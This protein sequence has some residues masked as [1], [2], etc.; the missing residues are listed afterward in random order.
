MK[1]LLTASCFLLPFIAR[2][3]QGAATGKITDGAARKG[4]A[5]ATITIFRAKD[6][7]IVT[8]RLSTETG[9]FKVPGLP[10]NLPLRLMVTFSG[11]EPL[12]KD[13][14]LTDRE[15]SAN[16]G[17]LAL[18]H[19]SKQLDEVIVFSER[20]P[21][22]IKKDTIEFN[23]SA[24]KTLPSA[25][26]EDLLKKL[27]GVIVNE[28][29]DIT[30][31]G[32]KVNRLLVDGKRFF[33]DNPQ[34]AT[35]NLPS[36]L[37]DKVQVMD[38]REEIDFNNDGD[39]SKI[40]KVI[41]ITLKKSIRKAMFGRVF[42]GGGTDSRYETGAI[43]NSF[44][45]TLQLSLV[46]FANNVNRASFTTKDVMQLGG[47]SRSGWGNLNGNSNQGGQQGFTIDGFSLGG[48][49]AGLNSANGIGINLN[50]SPSNKV[51]FSF[52]YMYGT[53]RN[54][55]E[56]TQNVQ[57]FFEDTIVNTRTVT[58]A[59][60]TSRTHN[61]AS[62]G[63]WKPDSLTNMTMRLA[64]AHSGSG[65]DAPSFIYTNNN[66]AGE[67]NNGSNVLRID[68]RS[69]NYSEV[70]MFSHRSANVK[71]RNLAIT[72]ALLHSANPV[73]TITESLIN[74]QYPASSSLSLQQLRATNTPST[75][76]F[77][78]VNYSTP[79][80][81]R[82]TFRLN[83][84][85]TYQENAQDVSTYG[86][87]LVTD[88]YDSLNS[89]LSSH[90]GR[91]MTRLSSSG[92]FS[93]RIGQVNLNAGAAFLQQW[94]NNHFTGA[95]KDSK[96]YYSDI[97][98][99]LSVNWK[100]ISLGFNQDVNAPGINYLIPT[101][102]NSNPFL[103]VY[104]NPALKPAK[105][106][107]LNF[108]GNL[109]NPK[110][111]LNFYFSGQST[112]TDNATIQ[113]V[114]LGSN[115]IQLNQPINV[116]GL[117]T[118]SLDMGFSKQYRNPQQLNITATMGLTGNLNRAPLRFNNEDSRLTNITLSGNAGIALNWKDLI[119]FN[120]RWQISSNH[121]S[122]S[123]RNFNGRDILMQV[124]QGEFIVRIPKIVW[125]TNLYYRRLNEVS[126]GLPN[127]SIYWNAAVTFLM[128][129]QDKG[130]LRIAVYDILN[131]NTNL[132]R[133][134]STNAIIDNRSNVLQR[135][136]LLTYTYQIRSFGNQPAKVGGSR[137]I[138]NF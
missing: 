60:A 53:T 132:S 128:F 104:G 112:L 138:F 127:T 7:S 113:S 111:N 51:N 117:W 37:I 12:R 135:Y 58:T 38:D 48:T 99:N 23:A 67:V 57:R 77:L 30:V 3:Q 94:I 136:F 47:F 41:N 78:F 90:L 92:V 116:S 42:A 91:E 8:Y 71:G 32:Q 29:G 46:G 102:D 131:S 40:G 79:L 73:S 109:P 106:N 5:L 84:F 118:N 137:S 14:T 86:K 105:R 55:L 15:P 10:F 33:G 36:N 66:K 133:Y 44:R 97:L 107:T 34:M 4:L 75:S 130:Q 26:L 126:P 120:P 11:Y 35:R 89:S 115:G 45:D 87:H 76:A 129:K 103:I 108:N 100:K 81:A 72:Q 110:T 24:F 61:F 6:T 18:I 54:D 68:G 59:L 65:S 74:Y 27:P 80:S 17:E 119:E 31:N 52:Q 101:P 9:E 70:F 43:L 28:N 121:S 16:F 85:L 95:T 69:D 82:L 56:Q 98:F 134:Y 122:Y 21:V 88:L 20:P 49:G 114:V 1:R 63:G 19:T 2:A 13:F 124:V 25:L 96:Q 93:Y 39:L 125:E 83:P 123:S 50:H 62:S 64:Y 22:V